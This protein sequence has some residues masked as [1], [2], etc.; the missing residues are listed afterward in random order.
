MAEEEG[1]P[2]TPV[3]APDTEPK[4]EDK[5][6]GKSPDELVS[7]LKNQETMISKQGNDIGDLRNEIVR[8]R[9]EQRLALEQ[10][11]RQ[12]E[13]VQPQYTPQQPR[14]EPPDEKRF[15]YEK[16]VTSVYGLVN[17]RLQYELD[18]REAVR[19]QYEQKMNM[20]RAMSA[21]AKGRDKVFARKD[22]LY[23]GIEPAVEN[24]VQQTFMGGK[25]PIE[26]L[27]DEETWET[28]AQIIRLKR[29]EYDKVSRPKTQPVSAPF[30]EVSAQV[31]DFGGGGT[32]PD[33]DEGAD[34]MIRN[35]G[36]AAGIKTREQAAEA[37]RG[38]KRK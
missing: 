26:D 9:E 3:I 17:E 35:L 2:V 6:T 27:R 5:W 24:L 7:M 11:R 25:M 4:A 30:G 18:N 29:K 28:A 12:R 34:A 1:K 14:Y 21:Y 15:D 37:L 20:E 10:D 19:Q 13:Y 36:A 32:M 23:E 8:S 38:G 33:F 16:P 22:P 31:K